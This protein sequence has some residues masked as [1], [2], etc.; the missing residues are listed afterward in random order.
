MNLDGLTMGFAFTGSF[1]TLKET[2][3]VL[4]ELIKE[5]VDVYPIVSF[6]VKKLDTRFGK[7]KDFEDK[8]EALTGK[9]PIDGI[10]EAE[11]IGP[12]SFLDVLVVAPCTGNTLSKIAN[13]ITDTPVTMAVKAQ[14]RNQKP[15]VISV[16]TNDGLGASMRN[17]GVLQNTKNIYIV[18]YYQD[19]PIDKPNSIVSSLSELKT[20]VI[21]ALRGG[22]TQPLLRIKE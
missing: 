3:P 1:C 22:Q 14:I 4:E 13:G 16:S 11:P 5:G 2:L 17:L 20:T 10:V 15:V 6:N 18:P 7:A 19:S 12:K 8:L 9:K 21:D